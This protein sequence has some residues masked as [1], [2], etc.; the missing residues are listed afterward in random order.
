M[1]VRSKH[2]SGT[3]DGMPMPALVADPDRARTH[4]TPTIDGG[5]DVTGTTTLLSGSH[6]AM[7]AHASLSTG[8]VGPEIYRRVV[9]RS[10]SLPGVLPS[11]SNSQ[12]DDSSHDTQGS[13]QG[14]AYNTPDKMSD[15]KRR[16]VLE[17]RHS[18]P[19]MS[20]VIRMFQCCECS[21]INFSGLSKLSNSFQA[22]ASS[23]VTGQA[24]N[25]HECG[26]EGTLE[27][28]EW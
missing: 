16:R 24:R 9:R 26:A 14:S 23:A 18:M 8:G 6:R 3:D 2:E 7:V 13:L 15:P 17:A 22:P 19:E 20:Q 27:P 4:R 25:C 5:G 1:G 11:R 12:Q 10:R 21:S 28:W